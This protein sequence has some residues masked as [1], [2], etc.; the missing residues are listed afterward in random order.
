MSSPGRVISLDLGEKRIGMAVCDPD[1][2][3]AS[4]YSTIERSG[5]VALDHREV[6]AAVADL[7]AVR[8]VVGLPLNMSGERG[9]RAVATEQEVEKLRKALP[10][11]V[12]VLDERLTTVSA[13]RSLRSAGLS[14]RQQRKG[15]RIDQEAAAVLLQAW[16]DRS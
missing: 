14:S 3:L 8:V 12:E 11:P 10:V 6:F 9:P 5:D 1:G 2:V 7:G 4:P 13:A 15:G 16:L